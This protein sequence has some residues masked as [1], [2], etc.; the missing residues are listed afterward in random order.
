MKGSEKYKN[1]LSIR[2]SQS[3][4]EHRTCKVYLDLINSNEQAKS[5]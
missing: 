4:E 5:L 2:G 1:S 3:A